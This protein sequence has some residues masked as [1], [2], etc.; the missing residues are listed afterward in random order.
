MPTFRTVAC[1]PQLD[2]SLD[3]FGPEIAASMKLPFD[4]GWH[5]WAVMQG[6]FCVMWSTD[7]DLVSRTCSAL[8][9]VKL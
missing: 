6:D 7:Y 1:E 5:H 2:G 9:A 8:N 3:I 4:Q